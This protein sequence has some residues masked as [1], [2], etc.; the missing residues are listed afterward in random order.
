MCI[1]CPTLTREGI[2][3]S[4]TAG[5]R[6]G[7]GQQ[8]HYTLVGCVWPSDVV[9]NQVGWLHPVLEYFIFLSAVLYDSTGEVTHS[10]SQQVPISLR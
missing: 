8:S 7:D 6:E 10:G 9:H 4:L 3:L 5:I 2:H 1:H